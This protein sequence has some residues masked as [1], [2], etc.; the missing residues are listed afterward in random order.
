MSQ[1]TKTA[2]A[3]SIASKKQAQLE[4]G[5]FLSVYCTYT[6]YGIIYTLLLLYYTICTQKLLQIWDWFLKSLV[7]FFQ[8]KVVKVSHSYIVVVGMWRMEVGHLFP[9]SHTYTRTHRR[10]Q[11]SKETEEEEEEKE[12]EVARRHAEQKQ[13]KEEEERD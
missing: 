11:N 13:L 1:R 2:A 4:P 5:D 8:M 3:V 6:S 10:I 7:L 12:N 9:P